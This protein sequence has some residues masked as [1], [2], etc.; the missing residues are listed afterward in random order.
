VVISLVEQERN[1]AGPPRPEMRINV[2]VTTVATSLALIAYLLA[3]LADVSPPRNFSVVLFAIAPACAIPAT[4]LLAVRAR[5]E[6][7]EPLR[8]VTSGLAIGCVAM[9]L[10][11]FAFR[12]ISPGGGIF[13]TSLSGSALLYLMWHLAL[14]SGVL[15]A[16]IGR[17]RTARRRAGLVIGVVLAL[18]IATAVP[19][20]WHLAR[21]NGDYSPPLLGGM[22]FVIFATLGVLLRWVRLNGLRPTA[23]RGWVTVAMV[24]SV[25]D[26]LLN[27]LGRQRYSDLWWASLGIRSATYAVLLGGLIINTARQLH[28]LERYTTTELARAEGEVSSWAEV[29]ERLLHATSALSAAVT[30]DRVALL[31]TEA[32]ASAVE[33]ED[34]AVYLIDRDEPGRLRTIGVV[35]D[36]PHHLWAAQSARTLHSGV[37]SLRSPLFLETPADIGAM[38]PGGSAPLDRMPVQAAAALPLLAGE[39]VVGALVLTSGRARPFRRLERELL[40]ALGRV[41]AQALERALLYEQKSSLANTLQAALLP[42]SLPART[43]VE[44]AGR[45]E[46]AHDDVE[47]GGDW[48]DVIEVGDEHVVLVVGDVMGK[49]VRA[50]TLMGEMRSAVRTLASVDADP[51][52]ILT[53]LDQLATGFAVDDIVTVVIV[54]LDLRSG[55]GLIANAGHLA[56]IVF[57]PGQRGAAAAATVSPPIGVPVTGPRAAAVLHL[58][59]GASM[60]LLT[61][62]LVEE[63]GQ[64]LDIGLEA[65]IAQAGDFLA[66]PRLSLERVADALMRTRAHRGDDVTV[67][68]ARRPAVHAAADEPAVEPVS[69]LHVE[70][71]ADLE[72]VSAA[73][74]LVRTCVLAA[75]SVTPDLLDA[76]LLVTSELVTN[77]L[78]HGEPP[79]LLTVER[80]GSRLRLTV[81]D[82]G[83]RIPRPRV[84]EPDATGGRG[85]FLVSAMSTA[86]K[87][88]THAE[89]HTKAAA[90]TVEGRDDRRDTAVGTTVWA[91][92]AL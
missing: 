30:A 31:L 1:P 40:A 6:Q 2:L 45:Y 32:A 49:G 5:A 61:D 90:T 46:P 17:P 26:V 79:V 85:L 70:L 65:L 19:D 73:R 60:L 50:A 54:R 84:A 38:F 14:P 10:Q 37:M 63:R 59:A 56:P 20:S 28:R 53:G 36:Q 78:R 12:T 48:Y 82:E 81:S 35:G 91:E 76:L 23:T 68:L 88:E 57:V 51:A 18:L 39:T 52:A 22:I 16:T 11:L 69:L 24:L 77:G 74:N 7:D 42:Q 89:R 3:L 25:Y 67:L 27:T 83:S 62:G 55:E 72:A 87:I 66:E 92:F 9:V 41:G 71:G 80:R 8:G 33:M 86:W 21:P 13:A 43:D 4:M 29:T 58:P 64:D 34:A 15:A 47:V 75:E 44:L